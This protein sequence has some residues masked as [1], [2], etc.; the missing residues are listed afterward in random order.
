MRVR[1]TLADPAKHYWLR[2]T[3]LVAGMVA[4]G[5][6]GRRT[7]LGFLSPLLYSLAGAHAFHD[8]PPL[9]RSGPQAYRA[10]YTPGGTYIDHKYG[11]GFLVGVSEA[12]D[13]NTGQVATRATAR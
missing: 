12:R 13:P 2:P 10:V 1:H 3:P 6:Q 9:S 4:D 7:P 5:E 11:P 8:V